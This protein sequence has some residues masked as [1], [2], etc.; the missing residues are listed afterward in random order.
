MCSKLENHWSQLCFAH[1]LLFSLFYF[2]KKKMIAFAIISCMCTAKSWIGTIKPSETNATEWH[3]I[4]NECDRNGMIN[5]L[6]FIRMRFFNPYIH[7]NHYNECI[8][9]F[10]QWKILAA[11]DVRFRSIDKPSLFLMIFNFLFAIGKHSI[12]FR[13]RNATNV[14]VRIFC[15]PLIRWQW[16][17]AFVWACV[18][19]IMAWHHTKTKQ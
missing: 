14:S 6:D 9:Q 8:A 16:L 13:M 12:P 19:W 17:C 5:K 15:F 10:S 11:I 7:N 4:A 2:G 18:A 3:G 1:F